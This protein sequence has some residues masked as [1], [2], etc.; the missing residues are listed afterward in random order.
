MIFV[1]MTADILICRL[2]EILDLELYIIYNLLRLNDGIISLH[3]TGIDTFNACI[4]SSNIVV[5]CSH[6][7]VITIR[8]Y[9]QQSG[10]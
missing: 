10:I 1:T 8:T 4:E 3:I 2:L 5:T 6:A 7:L 9:L